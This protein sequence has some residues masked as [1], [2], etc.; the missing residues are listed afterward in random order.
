MLGLLV[1]TAAAPSSCTVVDLQSGWGFQCVRMEQQMLGPLRC[2]GKSDFGQG[3]YGDYENRGDTPADMGIGLPAIPISVTAFGFG[4]CFMCGQVNATAVQCWGAN[5]YG[6]L[7]TGDTVGRSDMTALPTVPLP[8]VCTVL[9]LGI[10]NIHACIL[11]DDQRTLYCWGGNSF[12]QL[13]A[14]DTAPRGNVAGWTSSWT[15]VD[16]GGITVVKLLSQPAAWHTCVVTDG[17]QL[18]CWGRNEDGQLGIGTAGHIGDGPGEMGSNLVPVNFGAHSPSVITMGAFHTCALYDVSNLVEC[19]G[20]NGYGQAGVDSNTA[21]AAPDGNM[22]ILSNSLAGE[23]PSTVA[24]GNVFSCAVSTT[25]MKLSCWGGNMDAQLGLGDLV[26]RGTGE[27]GYLMSS[28]PPISFGSGG[29]SPKIIKLSPGS[30]HTCVLV[31]PAAGALYEVYCW[32]KNFQGGLGLGHTTNPVGGQAGDMAALLPIDLSCPT[33]TSSPSNTPS[34]SPSPNPSVS[35]PTQSPTLSPTLAPS[36]PPLTPSVSPS[37][38]PTIT[39]TLAPSSPPLTPSVSPS[40]HPTVT[41]STSPTVTPTTSTPSN[42]PSRAP[43][44]TPTRPPSLPPTTSPTPS[45][46]SRPSASP[47]RGPSASPSSSSPTASPTP[48]PS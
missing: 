32:G 16:L 34:S 37:M 38:H 45:P 27:A 3:G 40:M 31:E 9:R 33:P 39:P 6:Q 7:G 22:V 5:D 4:K 2:W 26:N 21:K 35:P 18:I 48:S 10:Y 20:N 23:T 42:P 19:W 11:C 30:L 47:T 41:P 14:G 44:R 43:S 12:G 1:W 36:S 46:S 29:T 25:G 15:P 28:L 24:A 8:S 17:G 13:G